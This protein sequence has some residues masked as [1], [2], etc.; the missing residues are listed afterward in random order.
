MGGWYI[1]STL[2]VRFLNWN[3][4]SETNETVTGK[5][6]FFLVGPF[7]TSHS[8]CVNIRYWHSSFVW[9]CCVFNLSTKKCFSSFLK[10]VSVFQ[11]ICLKIEALKSFKI[12]SNCH[13]RTCWSLKRRA[14]LKRADSFLLPLS[15]FLIDKW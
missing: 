9:K 11:K 14:I 5:T 15:A 2:Y 8:I 10:R 6:L 3:K 13:I 7:C 12:S 4:I 1:K